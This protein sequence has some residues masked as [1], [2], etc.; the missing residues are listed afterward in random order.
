MVVT[1]AHRASYVCVDSIVLLEKPV[2]WLQSTT[3]HPSRP[4]LLLRCAVHLPL[5]VS[6]VTVP[7]EWAA[8]VIALWGPRLRVA[9]AELLSVSGPGM[10][11]FHVPTFRGS[12]VAS[13]GGSPGYPCKGQVHNSHPSSLGYP[14]LV[15]GGPCLS[16]PPPFTGDA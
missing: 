4:P 1:A 12:A 10:G 7:A 8:H 9:V 14:R 5:R 3:A 2:L 11:L 13:P 16:S 6:S 15:G